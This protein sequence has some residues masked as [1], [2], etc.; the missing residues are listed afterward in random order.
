MIVQFEAFADESGLEHSPPFIVVS[1]YI[2]AP[3]TWLRFQ[4]KWKTALREVEGFHAKQFFQRDKKQQS[5]KN[6]YVG[7]SDKKALR[8]LDRLIDLI[9][10]SDIE[11]VGGAIKIADFLA[12][13]E[14]QRR[15]VTGG[16]FV[17][18]SG[19]WTDSGS[20]SRPYHAAFYQFLLESIDH[21]ASE[22]SAKI[23]FRFDCQNVMSGRARFA[24]A[25]LKKSGW[26][27]T[28]RLESLEY[29]S[30]TEHGPLQAADLLTHCWYSFFRDGAEGMGAERAYALDKLTIKRRGMRYWNAQKYAEFF[31]SPTWTSDQRAFMEQ[32]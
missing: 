24:F 16:N 4:K 19:K 23:H 27:G 31:A 30:S 14:N 28:D 18:P 20:P 26:V 2:G 25:R 5:G 9:N 29:W 7:W 3:R 21:T 12:L 17:L 1:G 11:P 13:T 22:A 32:R 6:P 8:F 15:V 10:T